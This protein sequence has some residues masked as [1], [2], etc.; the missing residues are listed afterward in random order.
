MH[1]MCIRCGVS[2][3]ASGL[4][5]QLDALASFCEQRQL[6][7]N[8]SKSKVVV[9]EARQSDV[10]DFVL[11]D[12]IV[13]CVES[14]KCLGFV[15][16]ATKRSTFGTDALVATAKKGLF[17]MRRR[18]ALLGIRDL[19]LQCK[20][21]DTLLLPIL[22]YGCEVWIVDTRCSTAAEA[23]RWDILR[24]LLGVKKSTAILMVLA[25]LGRFPLQ[26]QFWQQILRYYHRT[27]ALDNVRLIKLAMVHGF[28]SDRSQR[29][30]AALYRRFSTWSFRTAAAFSRI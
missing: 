17:A 22:S 6:T 1:G 20:L 24:R 23:L 14:Y 4:Q 13:E 5:K 27:T 3:S 15:V 11:S 12:A 29:Q 9:F 16:H 25:E 18:C 8:L 19:A 7:V 30:L 26:I 28:A 10:R 21:F 2:V